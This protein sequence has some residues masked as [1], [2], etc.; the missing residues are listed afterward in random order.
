M[1]PKREIDVENGLLTYG[2]IPSII[3][4]KTTLWG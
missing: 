4:S 3:I 2:G 1:N